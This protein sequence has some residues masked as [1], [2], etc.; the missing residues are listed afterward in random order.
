MSYTGH[1]LGKSYPSAE[2]QLVFSTVPANLAMSKLLKELRRER[3][4]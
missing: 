1:S 2:M 4:R 3:K